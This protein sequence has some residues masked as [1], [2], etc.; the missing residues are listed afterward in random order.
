MEKSEYIY[1]T[2]NVA[3]ST[4][5][6]GLTGVQLRCYSRNSRSENTQLGKIPHRVQFPLELSSCSAPWSETR[7]KMGGGA[8]AGTDANMIDK[9]RATS[10]PSKQASST[11]S[12]DQY[13]LMYRAP[14]P[15]HTRSLQPI[16]RTR[17]LQFRWKSSDSVACLLGSC[18]R[19]QDCE[20]KQ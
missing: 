5:M 12:M 18:A 14:P 7:T 13:Q 20:P 2:N 8:E 11:K 16:C 17:R 1:V 10:M 3:S 19:L 6:E 9:P 4:A 15:A